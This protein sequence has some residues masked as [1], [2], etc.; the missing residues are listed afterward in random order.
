[1]YYATSYHFFVYQDGVMKATE[2]WVV[3]KDTHTSR[4][5]TSKWFKKFIECFHTNYNGDAYNDF[6]YGDDNKGYIS[7][8]VLT[9]HV[10][11]HEK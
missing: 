3:D 6:L 1:M 7:D 5:K 8:G 9:I 2:T 11:H 10:R 4:T